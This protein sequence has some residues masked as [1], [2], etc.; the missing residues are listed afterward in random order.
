MA[1]PRAEELGKYRRGERRV[2]RGAGLPRAGR[3]DVPRL[4]DGAARSAC[5][6]CVALLERGADMYQPTPELAAARD[7][8]VTAAE[9]LWL[10]VPP[11]PS[12][13]NA[14]TVAY[15]RALAARLIG[16]QSAS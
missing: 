5:M 4:L 13:R 9:A 7:E 8:L 1:R 14:A 11:R 10:A 3:P 15:M 2:R 12:G 16:G 6:H